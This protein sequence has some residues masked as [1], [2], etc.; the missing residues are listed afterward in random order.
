[1]I[2]FNNAQ[3]SRNQIETLMDITSTLADHTGTVELCEKIPQYLSKA[4]SLDPITLA[5][6]N[7]QADG[8]AGEIKFIATADKAVDATLQQN[9]L[10]LYRQTRPLSPAEA[11]V[12]RSTLGTT[13]SSSEFTFKDSLSLPRAMVI[14][15]AID[16][17]HRLL[18]VVHQSGDRAQT[19]TAS[20]DILALV[21]GH[22]AKL[23]KCLVAWQ[24]R[25]EALGG[26]FNRLTDREWTVLRALN[27]DDGEKQLADRLQLSPHTLHSHIKSI[28]RK[29]GVQGRLPLLQ[30]LNEALL[31]LRV[32]TINMRAAGLACPEHRAAAAVG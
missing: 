27:S 31:N 26:P 8:G 5:V 19:S 17:S 11:P 16:E 32:T 23:L 3:W 24:D 1:M 13:A 6:V 4:L 28:Y 7:T 9:V 18:V 10:E 20:T 22:L 12:L 21:A 25:P 14:N 29:V 2:Q 30:Q 15:C